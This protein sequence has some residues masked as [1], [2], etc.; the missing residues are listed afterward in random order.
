[1]VA[2]CILALALSLPPLVEEHCF[3]CHGETKVEGGFDLR[4]P[5]TASQW[6]RAAGQVEREE[7]PP[8][9]GPTPEARQQILAWFENSAASAPPAPRAPVPA[10]AR[11]TREEYSRSVANLLG[12]DLRPGD[13]LEPDP[14]GVS[15]FTNDADSLQVTPAQAARY[16]EA[17]E[18]A[19]EGWLA[20]GQPGLVRRFEAEAMDRSSSHLKEFDRGMLF[21][22]EPQV[23]SATVEIPVDGYYEVRCHGSTMGRPTR[24][25]ILDGSEPIVSIP[26]S[27]PRPGS[28]THRIPLLLRKGWHTLSFNQPSLVPQASLPRDA[29]RVMN[30]RAARNRMRVPDLPPD[31]TAAQETAKRALEEKCLYLQQAFEWLYAYGETGDPRDIVRFRDYAVERLQGEREARA[32]YAADVLKDDGAEFNRRWEELNGAILKRYEAHMKRISS[33]KWMDWTRHQGQLY[34]DWVELAGPVIPAGA[35]PRLPGNLDVTA[36]AREAWQ[37]EPPAGSLAA[38]LTL[39]PRLALAAVLASPRFVFRDNRNP[40]VRLGFFLHGRPV[41]ISS[42]DRASI[43]QLMAAPAFTPVLAEFTGQWLGT[44]PLG[45][46]MMPDEYRF[47]GYKRHIALAAREE[48]VQFLLR[49][50]REGRSLRE[51]LD[52][53]W[54]MVNPSL[55]SFYGWPE[56]STDAWHPISLSNR[57]RGGLLGMSAVLTSTSSALRT[58][59]VTRGKWV[60]ETLLGRNPGIPLPDAG[61]LPAMAGEEGRTLREELEAH[62]ADPRCQRCHEKLDP[63]GLSLENFD[64]VGAWRETV[65]GKPID[66]TGTFYRGAEFSGAEGLRREL[67][68]RED[69]FLEQLIRQLLAYAHGRPCDDEPGWIEG[70][71]ARVKAAGWNASVLFEEVALNLVENGPP[72]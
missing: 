60:W 59:P 67:L 51:L 63:I 12:I 23:I 64:A 69:E 65:A 39:E 57:R 14:P 24:L 42:F 53:D 11:L 38:Y 8:K 30:E 18:R 45:V 44:A 46:T 10:F 7:M 52:S 27:H 15:G 41:G 58:T 34:L 35:S 6:R 56:P 62:R 13:L 36:L 55:A 9:N 54:T 26:V 29:D 43:R 4:H 40:S 37:T 71:A 25:Q 21:A 32:R 66:P 1:M 68:R 48:P 72:P 19:I 17:A 2:P 31:A 5:L 47:P 22:T 50:I 28:T 70:I 16:L 3:S 20:L 61:V 49:L 33:I